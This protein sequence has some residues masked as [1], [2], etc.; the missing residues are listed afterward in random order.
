MRKYLLLL[1][2]VAAILNSCNDNFNPN[3][4]FKPVTIV[5]AL[6]DA[7]ETDHYVRIQKAFLDQNTNA[8]TIAE[9]NDSIYYP[10]DIL[11]ILHNNASGANDT[12]KRVNADS[13]GLVKDTGIFSSQPNILYHL[14]ASLIAG[15]NYTL[16]VSSE[17][18][19]E[20]NVSASE[21]LIDK[22]FPTY[23]SGAGATT[24]IISDTDG[25]SSNFFP[26]RAAPVYQIVVRFPYKEWLA[27]NPS[28]VQFK[29]IDWIAVNNLSPSNLTALV[30]LVGLPSRNLF[31]QLESTLPVGDD[32]R[33]QFDAAEGL[34]FF[35]YAGGEA[36]YNYIRVQNAQGGIT[37]NEALPNYTNVN[38][39]LGIFST[40]SVATTL[41]VSIK[42]EDLD[43]LSCG[44]ITRNLNFSN[45]SGL[46]FNCN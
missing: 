29:H 12:L 20:E 14:K 22:P 3:G 18:K 19:P 34:T 46:F 6:L 7:G 26:V 45:S 23:P 40:R 21:T 35:Y 17:T 9:I 37:S 25:I 39:G 32:Y 10:D 44:C 41:G 4:D 16:S 1:L 8:L 43:S 24:I 27:S 36:Y 31:R 11:V 5:Y 30:K 33:R 38:N 15:N 13:L 28:D 2:L 42:D